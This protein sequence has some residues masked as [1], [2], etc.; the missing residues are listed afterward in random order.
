MHLIGVA[1]AHRTSADDGVY[2]CFVDHKGPSSK[3]DVQV[4]DRILSINGASAIGNTFSQVK[5][6]LREC[7]TTADVTLK[8]DYEGF[9]EMHRKQLEVSRRYYS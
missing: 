2:I 1:D 6:M 3:L 8:F 5:T 4:G 9:L 7:Q